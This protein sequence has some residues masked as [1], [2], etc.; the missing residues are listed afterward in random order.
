ML[1]SSSV[2]VT[3]TVYQREATQPQ[4]L[5]QQAEE[6]GQAQAGDKAVHSL[7]RAG[8]LSACG[9]LQQLERTRARGKLIKTDRRAAHHL[10]QTT[11]VKQ[12]S[13][14]SG[15]VNSVDIRRGQSKRGAPASC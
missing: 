1:S 5:H 9:R 2:A 8:A 6:D 3:G 11:Q 14:L 13:L 10:A 4:G 15:K 7:L 12:C